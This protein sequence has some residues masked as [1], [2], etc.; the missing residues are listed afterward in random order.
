MALL[1]IYDSSDWTIRYTSSVRGV[2]SQVAASDVNDLATQLDGLVNSCSED[3]P[4]DRILFE[5]H[6]SPGLIS[7]GDQAIDASW[8]RGM[9]PH[10]Y[11]MLATRNARVYF[12]GCNVAEGQAGWLFLEA[13]AALFLTP[14]GGQVFGQTSMGFANPFNG[15]VVHLWGDT[16]RLYVDASGRVV[17]RFEQ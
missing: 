10:Q 12:N 13:A 9:I 5:T 3:S 15:H 2:V 4:F 16:R 11:T 8:L 6:G 1:H 14:G 17:E 7:F